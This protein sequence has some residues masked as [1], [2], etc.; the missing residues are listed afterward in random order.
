MAAD[1]GAA[2]AAELLGHGSPADWVELATFTRPRAPTPREQHGGLCIWLTDT[3]ISL[4][5]PSAATFHRSV[6]E[7][8]GTDGLQSAAVVNVT[9]E[10]SYETLTFHRICVVRNGQERF[11]DPRTHAQV[12]RREPD[13]ERA[14]YDGRLTANIT[15]P[16]IRVG[17]LVDVAFSVSGDHPIVGRHFSREWLFNWGCWVGET[18]VRLLAPVERRLTMLGW[19]GA[20]AAQDRLLNGACERVWRS[21]QTEPVELEPDMPAWVRPYATI[22]VCDHTA[23][24]E[25]AALFAPHYSTSGVLPPA[26]EEDATAL[27]GLEPKARA[28]AALRLVQSALRYQSVSLGEGGFVPR[29]LADIWVSRSGDCKDACWSRCSRVSD[30]RPIPCSSIP[31]RAGS[32]TRSRPR[33]CHST[34][35]SSGS[36]LAPRPSGWT[37]PWRRRLRSSTPSISP[38]SVGACH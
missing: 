33:R 22:R 14:I 12:F 30:S 32:S 27:V 13:L 35:V 3:Q 29:S 8:T 36:P 38:A 28:A 1:T 2:G 4:L 6:K 23:W 37:P 11:I 34:T 26:L 7:V 21:Q 18:R 15:L 5:G 20:P 16:D 10:P 24:P 31:G 17:D 9:F 19:S 25:V